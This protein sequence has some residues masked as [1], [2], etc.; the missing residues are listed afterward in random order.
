M[1]RVLGAAVVT[2]TLGGGA[3]ADAAA[4][5]SREASCAALRDTPPLTVRNAESGRVAPVDA[6]TRAALPARILLG[7]AGR[8]SFGARHDFA[9]HDGGLYSRPRARGPQAAGIWQQVVLPACF[10]GEVASIS[11]D[12]DWLLVVTRAR[13]VFATS[14][15]DRGPAAFD[16][17]RHWGPVLGFGGGVDLPADTLAWASS[18]TTGAFRF[19]DGSGTLRHTAGAGTLYELR[20]GGQRITYDDPWLPT[21]GSYELC[22]PRDGRF[23]AAGI[24]AGGATVFLVGRHGELYT[25]SFDFDLSGAN[26]LLMKY[27]YQDQSGVTGDTIQLPRPGWRRQPSIRR[28]I[29]TRI[30]VLVTGTDE[31]QRLLRVEGLD[32]RGRTGVWQKAIDA[33]TWRWVRGGW[34]RS[35]A[36]LPAT[37]RPAALAAATTRA[38]RTS[39]GPVSIELPAVS[40]ACSPMTMRLRAPGGDAVEVRLH[41]VDAIRQ[42]RRGPGLDATPRGY[43]GQIE[44]PAAVLARIDTLDP[45]LRAVLTGPLGRRR[46]TPAP[47]LA[48]A[49]VLRFTAQCWSLTPDGSP[50][51]PP[52]L[53]E[54]LAQALDLG[55]PVNIV[56]GRPDHG[57]PPPVG[58]C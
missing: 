14:A 53:A 56:T 34:P 7:G 26:T 28:P 9:V 43:L 46:F 39:A 47:F 27:S 31:H 15:S 42:A 20:A 55:T 29:T 54:I 19:R 17:S 12:R 44:V 11:N 16:W 36:R 22:G 30:G 45:A 4:A 8:Q 35:G 24:A 40:A 50:A 57:A 41:A 6:A 52:R 23:R 38:Y 37:R 5:P 48:T 21:D 25:R 32:R 2:I 3:V 51:P 18:S 13:Q 10:A 58:V 33:R 1:R 49:D